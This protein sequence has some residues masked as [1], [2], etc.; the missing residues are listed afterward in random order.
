MSYEPTII[1]KKKD[2]ENAVSIFEEIQ[3]SNNENN[4]KVAIFLLNVNKS[5]TI[6]FD[7]LELV[8]CKPELSNFNDLVRTCL[9]DL[10]IDFQI[11]NL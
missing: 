7:D 1:I 9:W 6:K 4:S 3:Y 10:D 5:K 2:L 11:D 8:L